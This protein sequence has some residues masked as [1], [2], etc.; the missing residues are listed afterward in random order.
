MGA[1]PAVS[2]I[3][4][5]L[6]SPLVVKPLRGSAGLGVKLVMSPEHL[7][8][9]LSGSLLYESQVIVEPFV[10]G[11]ELSVVVVGPE[12]QVL[13]VVAVTPALDE[14]GAAPRWPR[15]FQPAGADVARADAVPLAKEAFTALGCRDV[16]IVDILVDARGELWVLEV[17]TAVELGAEGK[18][19]AAARDAGLSLDDAILVICAR[20]R[21]RRGRSAVDA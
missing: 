5:D 15:T 20:C 21:G 9:A 3:V 11:H 4:S 18:L 6:G 14:H 7:T 1:A 2:R 10:H 19:A 12:P 16:A 17:D 8:S 13:G